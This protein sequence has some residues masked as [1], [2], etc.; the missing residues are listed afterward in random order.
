[1]RISIITAVFNGAQTIEDTIHSVLGGG[2]EDFEHIVI[3]GGS[4]DGTLEI[5]KR[6]KHDKLIWISEPDDGIYDAMNK[7]IKLASGE[8]I[9]ILNSCKI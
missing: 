4:S 6:L 5:L 1:M 2:Y 9:I 7:G 8:I 3:D